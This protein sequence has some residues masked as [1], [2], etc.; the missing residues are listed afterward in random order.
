MG[1]W[2]RR[3]KSQ[4]QA[5]A[6][7]IAACERGQVPSSLYRFVPDGGSFRSRIKK[8]MGLIAD[9]PPP[10]RWR[11]GELVVVLR[12]PVAEGEGEE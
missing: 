10:P 11:G 12:F 3:Y 8:A 1:T 4:C 7:A 2:V 5:V 9:P 6:R